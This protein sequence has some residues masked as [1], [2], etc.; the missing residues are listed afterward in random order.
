MPW[1]DVFVR[2]KGRLDRQQFVIA[3]TVLAVATGL[4]SALI[5]LVPAPDDLASHVLRFIRIYHSVIPLGAQYA[6]TFVLILGTFLF[7]MYMFL[8][9]FVKRLRFRGRSV[10][11]TAPIILAVNIV[12]SKQ[13]WN[14][15]LE[16]LSVLAV[17]CVVI[18][19]SIA[20]LAIKPDDVGHHQ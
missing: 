1:L 17:A 19:I 11:W 18:G 16:S 4:V 10:F 8:A 6:A 3:L 9:V 14:L 15:S 7:I 20:E 5:F 2:L 12:A 13:V